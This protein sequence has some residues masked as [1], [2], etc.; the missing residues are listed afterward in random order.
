MLNICFRDAE[1]PLVSLSK[2][3]VNF[4]LVERNESKGKKILFLWVKQNF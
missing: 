1:S 4:L 2:E 3:A